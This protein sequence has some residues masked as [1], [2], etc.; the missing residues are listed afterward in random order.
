MFCNNSPVNIKQSSHRLL[1]GTN[2]FVFIEYLY[3]I[4][5]PFGNKVRN[6][7]VLFRIS[8][9][10]SKILVVFLTNTK[11]LKFIGIV[12]MPCLLCVY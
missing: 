11:L 3:A 7:A 9:C 10:L 1:G 6:S 12:L 5:L 8:N 4:L 2:V